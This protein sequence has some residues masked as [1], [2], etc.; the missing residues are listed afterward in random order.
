M[1]LIF[2]SLVRSM[3]KPPWERSMHG[4]SESPV[5][6]SFPGTSPTTNTRSGMLPLSVTH[7]P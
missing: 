6:A 3:H 7:R 4:F 5:F 2:L 1:F